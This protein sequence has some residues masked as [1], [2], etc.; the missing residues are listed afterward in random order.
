MPI[1]PI[2]FDLLRSSD[3]EQRKRGV[4]ALARTEDR[5]ALRYLATLYQQD[6]DPEVR[7]LALV[8]GQH[9]KKRRAFSYGVQDT[10][11]STAMLE[12]VEIKQDVPKQKPKNK[13]DAKVIEAK[14]L[15]DKAMGFVAHSD[16]A[17]AQNLAY[18]AFEIMPQL[19]S[20][21]YYA[22]LAAEI[23]GLSQKEAIKAL[24]A[25]QPDYE[26]G[27]GKR[28]V[29]KGAK[30]KPKM[31]LSWKAFVL[32][33]VIIFGISLV[34]E[35]MLRGYMAMDM[36]VLDILSGSGGSLLAIWVQFI[37]IYLAATSYLDGDGS[38]IDL[39]HDARLPLVL[40]TFVY[41]MAF[42]YL[43]D[44]APSVIA[45]PESVTP[46]I[47][48]VVWTFLGTVAAA[49][50]GYIVWISIV[51]GKTFGFNPFIGFVAIIWG[52]GLTWCFYYSLIYFISMVFMF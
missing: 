28:K 7:Q 35:I 47:L 25:G 21:P 30:S 16:Y 19:G 46:E 32:D 17:R 11:K 3:A 50:F 4:K 44:A 37:M 41:I 2:I 8:A 51:I 38:F 39:F 48:S 13:A 52:N 40:Q 34:M 43:S 23:M 29:K 18:E 20:D 1:D 14:A 31:I 15:M 6:T 24:Q 5:E 33:S 22:G 9:I 10:G 12:T 27:K 26:V 49:Y 36:N 45:N 42:S